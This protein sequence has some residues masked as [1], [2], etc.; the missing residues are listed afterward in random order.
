MNAPMTV[1]IDGHTYPSVDDRSRSNNSRELG[2]CTRQLNGNTDRG[3]LT[4]PPAD[5]RISDKM[6]VEEVTTQ[7]P[8]NL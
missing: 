6:D 4:A 8:T 1:E 2:G 5:Q 7:T 3:I